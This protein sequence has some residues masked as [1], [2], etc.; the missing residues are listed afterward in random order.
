LYRHSMNAAPSGWC[1]VWSMVCPGIELGLIT[2]L[3]CSSLTTP[4][5][6][7]RIHLWLCGGLSTVTWSSA[8][9]LIQTC[10]DPTTEIIVCEHFFFTQSILIAQTCSLPPPRPLRK[11]FLQTTDSACGGATPGPA[12]SEDR[13]TADGSSES[14][15]SGVQVRA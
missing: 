9:H 2:I 6:Q 12:E 3:R 8:F 5:C 15:S 13:C 10:H 7:F 11:P 4:R 1:L 14:A